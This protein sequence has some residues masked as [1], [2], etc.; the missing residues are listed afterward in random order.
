M[1]F[2]IWVIIRAGN[3]GSQRFH[4]YAHLSLLCQLYA[5]QPP[6]CDMTFV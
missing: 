2:E 3:K 5:D 6:P 1:I 4:Q